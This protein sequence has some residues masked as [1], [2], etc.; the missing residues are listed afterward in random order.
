MKGLKTRAVK[1]EKE[2]RRKKKRFPACDCVM[3]DGT[4]KRLYGLSVLLPLLDGEIATVTTEDADIA[5]LMGK[6]NIFEA[7]I[8]LKKEEEG[9]QYGIY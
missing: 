7:E 9:V 4:Q 8:I 6:M 3:R 5:T 2:Q 1:L